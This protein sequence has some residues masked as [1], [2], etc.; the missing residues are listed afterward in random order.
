MLT[1]H[2]D[3]YLLWVI[4]D[5]WRSLWLLRLW[6]SNG[7]VHLQLFHVVFSGK[8]ISSGGGSCNIVSLERN[9]CKLELHRTFHLYAQ[10]Q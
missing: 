1:V 4:L 7:C 9:F 8:F 3:V 10:D 5:L 2:V 6:S